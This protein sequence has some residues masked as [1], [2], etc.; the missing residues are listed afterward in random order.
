MKPFFLLL[1][2]E[3]RQLK[4]ISKDRS[5]SKHHEEYI[6]T[7]LNKLPFAIPLVTIPPTKKNALMSLPFLIP[8][9]SL[10]HFLLLPSALH[11]VI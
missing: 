4:P 9:V 10:P 6:R 2:V 11:R 3:T 8:R 1:R 5:I 7:P